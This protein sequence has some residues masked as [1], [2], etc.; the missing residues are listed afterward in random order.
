MLNVK[1]CRDEIK[2]ELQNRYLQVTSELRNLFKKYGVN[3]FEELKARFNEVPEE[4]G[5][6]DY[7]IAHNLEA[8]RRKLQQLL[9]V[10][11]ED[12]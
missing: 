2:A 4:E 6:D 10:L 12:K 8:L 9:S 11:E 5:L 7:F 1:E 3:S